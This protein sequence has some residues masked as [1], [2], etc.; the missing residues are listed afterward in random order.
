MLLYLLLCEVRNKIR[1]T[2]AAFATLQNVGSF[3]DLH[4]CAESHSHGLHSQRHEF[5]RGRSR[6]DG[7]GR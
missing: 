7:G 6:C 5:A 2:L 1:P 4:A 3:L